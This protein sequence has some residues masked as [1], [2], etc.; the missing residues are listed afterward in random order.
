MIQNL[1]DV[2]KAA[3]REKFVS[4]RSIS[5]KTRKI[6]NNLTLYLKQLE[7]EGQTKP[8]VSRRKEIIKIRADIKTNNSKD[9]RN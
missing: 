4:N 5:Q 3:L 6:S 1:Q 9:Q 2:A 8:K 7:K